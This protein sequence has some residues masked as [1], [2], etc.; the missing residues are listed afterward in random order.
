MVINTIELLNHIILSTERAPHLSDT[1]MN[2]ILR[3]LEHELHHTNAQDKG[4]VIFWQ[5]EMLKD[6]PK[7][8]LKPHYKIFRFYVY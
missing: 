5:K 1:R 7:Y 8:S 2:A 3:L 6:Y 4:V